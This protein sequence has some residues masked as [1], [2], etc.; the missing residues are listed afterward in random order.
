[1][2]TKPKPFAGFTIAE[3]VLVIGIIGVLFAIG[4]KTYREERDRFAYND[5]LSRIIQMIK[6]ARDYASTSR[7]AMVGGTPTIPPQGYGVYIERLPAPRVILFANTGS[8]ANRFEAGADGDLVEETYPLPSQTIFEAMLAG[9]TRETAVLISDPGALIIFRPPLSTPF[10]SNNAT[11]LFPTL[12]LRF[13]NRNAPAGA[14]RD[15]ISINRIAG[16]P[17]LEL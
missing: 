16:F 14:E 11:T 13:V 2:K 15:F 5:S 6:T 4:S 1:M 10:I 12:V 3:L 9:E 8:D 17:E 7:A